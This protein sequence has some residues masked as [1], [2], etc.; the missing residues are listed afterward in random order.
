M[1]LYIE[2][3]IYLNYISQ[4][5]FGAKCFPKFYV[6][7]QDVFNAAQTGALTSNLKSVQLQYLFNQL[8][9]VSS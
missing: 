5:C 4:I 8:K 9:T 1:K 2:I 3:I 7:K 6:P